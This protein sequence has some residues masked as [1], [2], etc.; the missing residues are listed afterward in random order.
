M[1]KTAIEEGK[2]VNKDEVSQ[3]TKR[4]MMIRD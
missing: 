3:Q 4:V 1:Q 2:S